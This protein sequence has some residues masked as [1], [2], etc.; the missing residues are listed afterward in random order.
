M[1][2]WLNADNAKLIGLVL[3]SLIAGLFGKSWLKRRVSQDG[4]VVATNDGE[5]SLIDKLNAD[6]ARREQERITDYQRWAQERAELIARADKMNEERNAAYELIGGLRQ[7][8]HELT[9][10]LLDLSNTVE[11]L[12][13]MND[14]LKQANDGL[15]QQLDAFM[16]IHQIGGDKPSSI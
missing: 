12:E 13:R 15:R 2:E 10:K 4:V 5:R 1:T 3:G 11:R 9:A 14:A 8:I 16:K 7:N 6:I